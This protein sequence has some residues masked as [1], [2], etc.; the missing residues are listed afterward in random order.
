MPRCFLFPGQGAQYPGMARDLYDASARVREIFAEASDSAGFD[1]A[2][3]TFEGSEE[4]LA[5]TDNTQIALTLANLAA[6]TVLVERGIT[7]EGAAGFSLGEYCAL[8][9]AGVLGLADLVHIVLVR[10]RL[11]EKG[12][13]SADGP[14]GPAGLLAVVGLA[15]EESAA[16]L[17]ELSGSEVYLANHSS[18]MQ[19]VVAGTAG[20][21]NAAEEAFDEAG[22]M[23]IVRLKVSGPFHSPLLAGVK[24]EFAAE[25]ARLEFRDPNIPV[26]ANVSGAR[27]R[28]GEEARLLCAEQIVSAV[29]WVDEESAI[30]DD[31]F[32]EVYEVGPGKVLT[33]LWKSFTKSL[34]CKPAGTLE[35]IETLQQNVGP[36][37]QP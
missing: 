23:K 28:T 32:D 25:L 10:G 9:A 35:A 24:E 26:Y 37:G 34:K 8:Y 19:V 1:C 15:S 36:G 22:A 27:I 11:M 14:E 33:G 13:R 20:G 4:E 29:R 31:G 3:L 7:P 30:L 16:V 12:S 21:L 5:R 18:P 2:R 17:D 6:L